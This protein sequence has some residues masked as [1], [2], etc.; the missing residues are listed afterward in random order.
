MR[1]SLIT[2]ICTVLRRMTASFS[3]LPKFIWK[4]FVYG[5]ENFINLKWLE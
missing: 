1:V 4:I 2:I 3:V 5:M